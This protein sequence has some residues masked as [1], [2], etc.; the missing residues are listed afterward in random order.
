MKKSYDSPSI[1][2]LSLGEDV[3]RMSDT[4]GPWIWGDGLLG[5]DLGGGDIL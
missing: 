4:T 5:Q 3:I 1:K 2:L